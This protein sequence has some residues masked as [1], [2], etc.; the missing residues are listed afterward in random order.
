[1]AWRY[2]GFDDDTVNYL[3]AT[4]MVYVGEAASALEVMEKANRALSRL[5][6]QLEPYVQAVISCQASPI[7]AARNPQEQEAA[8]RRLKGEAVPHT[9][10]AVVREIRNPLMSVGGFA[11]RL[12]KQVEGSG[13]L[14]RYA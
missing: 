2:F 7:L 5:S 9:L 12:P 13:H 10:N 1:M 3:L 11:Q 8:D 14:T 6:S 4:T